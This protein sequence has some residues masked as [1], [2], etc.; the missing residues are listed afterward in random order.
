MDSARRV[1]AI[2]SHVVAGGGDP[3]PTNLAIR[4]K[5]GPFIGPLTTD[6][7]IWDEAPAPTE[8]DLAEGEVLCEVVAVTMGAGQRAGLQGASPTSQPIGENL[9]MAQGRNGGIARVRASRAP[10][11]PVG[12]LVRCDSGWQ[13]WH[14]QSA[15]A[16]AGSA[17]MVLEILEEGDSG[18]LADPAVHTGLFGSNGMTAY[19][20]L[21]EWGRP[22]AGETVLVS[23]AAGSV[24]H[25][26]CQLAKAEGCRV[27]GVAGSADKCKRLREELAV[28]HTLSYRD[29]DFK[30]QLRE[31]AGPDGIDVYCETLTSPPT[32][33][34]RRSAA[35]SRSMAGAVDN[36]GG[37]ILEAAVPS[38]A[39][40]GRIVCCGSVS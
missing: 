28:D 40:G 13:Q 15:T 22:A 5:E 24:G 31:L 29:P 25:I 30:D 34:F 8:A 39:T 37:E 36:T 32:P 4:T 11:V 2:A 12:S 7:F 17:Q 16:P 23:A 27:I 10:A 19:F 38:M 1:G 3:P 20:F 18:V 35:A 21:T 26:V 6:A 14:V 33:P 9:V